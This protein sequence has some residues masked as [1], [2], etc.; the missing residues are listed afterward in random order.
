M[1]ARMAIGSQAGTHFE[2]ELNTMTTRSPVAPK[3][4]ALAAIVD[5]LGKRAPSGNGHDAWRQVFGQVAILTEAA[6]ALHKMHLARNPVE[7]EAA[8]VKKITLAAERFDREITVAINRI[9]KITGDGLA[10]I[11]RRR[12]AKIHLV[13]DRA[14]EAEIRAVFRSLSPTKQTEMLNHL[15]E[16]GDGPSLAAIIKAPGTLTGMA[17]DHRKKYELAYIARHAPEELAEEKTLLE[18]QET[19]FV[20]TR[21]AG[22][23]AK[24]YTDAATLQQITASEKASEETAAAF[25][26][27]VGS[28]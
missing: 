27:T 5:H 24:A 18:A 22:E 1:A 12:N 14:Y 28:A 6:W 21:T 3:L 13:A 11:E 8:H 23:V 17:D 15:T 7:T 4:H 20:T 16:Q 2:K 9:A 26:R 19:A 10:S 25:N